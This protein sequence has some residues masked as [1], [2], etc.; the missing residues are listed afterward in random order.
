MDMSQQTFVFGG[1]FMVV[2]VTMVLLFGSIVLVAITS[3]DGPGVGVGVGPG[4]GV[5]L[6]V[7]VGVGGGGTT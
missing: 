6:G 5:G 7:G 3:I 2:A 1:A 4:V